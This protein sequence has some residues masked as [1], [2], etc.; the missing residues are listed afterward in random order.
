MSFEVEVRQYDDPVVQALVGAVQAEYVDRYGGPD[1]AAVEAGEFDRPRGM[2][3]IGLLDGVA[4]ATGGWRWIEAGDTLTV[5]CKRM[6]V[7]AVARR[8]GF[9]RTILAEL[10]DTARRAG[11]RRIVLN[12]GQMQ[13]EAISLY[14]SSG[15]ART[16]GFGHYACHAGAVFY[17]KGL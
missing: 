9:A 6:F 13:P 11:A 16:A 3:L 5:E 15:Y 10:E 4:L 1:E 2:F 7:L 17:A 8:R 12:T 14:E